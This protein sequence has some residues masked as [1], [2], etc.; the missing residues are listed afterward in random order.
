MLRKTAGVVEPE[1]KKNLPDGTYHL[2]QS[3]IL[4]INFL[5][6]SLTPEAH[7]ERGQDHV[8][9]RSQGLVR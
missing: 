5:I 7:S 1:N 9:L 4:R 8:L 2:K 6:L 3:T